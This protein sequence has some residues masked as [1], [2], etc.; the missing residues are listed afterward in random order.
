MLDRRASLEVAEDHVPDVRAS[1][2]EAVIADDYVNGD[3]SGED[4]AQLLHSCVSPPPSKV[5][6][7]TALIKVVPD[8]LT[9]PFWCDADEAGTALSQ[10]EGDWVAVLDTVVE[11]VAPSF[12]ASLP[13]LFGEIMKLADEPRKK[14]SEWRRKAADISRR[15]STKR[16]KMRALRR[17]A[18]FDGQVRSSSRSSRRTKRLWSR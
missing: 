14:L 15:S 5:E 6:L 16:T 4:L 11:A 18:W 13:L 2:I 7:V 10:A 3:C 9:Q 12:E 17:S 8:S 1:S